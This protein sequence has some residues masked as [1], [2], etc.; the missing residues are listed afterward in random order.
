[1]GLDQG[2]LTLI[3]VSRQSPQRHID[4]QTTSLHTSFLASRYASLSGS[5]PRLLCVTPYF[6]TVSSLPRTRPNE[7]R[8]RDR[9]PAASHAA[10]F[11]S[12]S[13]FSGEGLGGIS[14]YPSPY[15]A[16]R[17]RS[18]IL[19]AS[20]RSRYAGSRAASTRRSRVV[21]RPPQSTSPC[22]AALR[23]VTAPL[24]ARERLFP[25]TDPLQIQT[26]F[27]IQSG[28]PHEA[29]HARISR[30]FFR[31]AALLQGSPC[32]FWTSSVDHRKRRQASKGDML[33]ASPQ[34]GLSDRLSVVSGGVRIPPSLS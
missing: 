19:R 13:L 18:C 31:G 5:L 15:L 28:G 9:F 27:A 23:I 16:R 2:S 26:T 14:P 32:F 4:T 33:G 3:L 29:A 24:G 10:V 22:R 11:A 8:L 30:Q 7:R 1:M 6:F 17:A 21:P 34:D 20:I 25:N 12:G